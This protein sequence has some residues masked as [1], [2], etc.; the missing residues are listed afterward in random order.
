MWDKTRNN[1]PYRTT[2]EKTIVF[3]YAF[4]IS[5]SLEIWSWSVTM[6]ITYK[7]SK[8]KEV[9]QKVRNGGHQ[10]SLLLAGCA[11]TQSAALCQALAPSPLRHR[12]CS[13]VLTPFTHG[14]TPPRWW[15]HR[16][17]RTSS[18]LGQWQAVRAVQPGQVT[19]RCRKPALQCL[20]SVACRTGYNLLK[21]WL[22]RSY[23]CL[24]QLMN[25]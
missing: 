3:D 4:K 12:Q 10:T 20:I 9:I 11:C 5:I 16:F 23:F 17:P 15:P 8:Q 7:K 1:I 2:L 22:I 25:S 6:D 24:R 18:P 21:W 19:A 14:S 13:M